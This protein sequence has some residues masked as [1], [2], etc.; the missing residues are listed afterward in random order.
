MWRPTSPAG[1]VSMRAKA[2]QQPGCEA[3]RTLQLCWKLHR[4]CLAQPIS[5][6][7]TR[8]SIWGHICC[9]P[10]HA[11]HLDSEVCGFSRRCTR[12]ATT[13]HLWLQ[14]QTGPAEG[15]TLGQPKQTTKTLNPHRAQHWTSPAESMALGQPKQKTYAPNPGP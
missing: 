10:Q 8:V 13:P 15:M 11:A 14:H 1:A 3:L 5:H 2:Y 4:R 7:H 6:V 12:R 9:Q